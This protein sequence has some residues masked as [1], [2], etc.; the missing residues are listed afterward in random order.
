M[1]NSVGVAKYERRRLNRI[2][3]H[4][5]WRPRKGGGTFQG[6][7]GTCQEEH[8]GTLG[9]Q[10]TVVDHR[11]RQKTSFHGGKIPRGPHIP[12]P[13]GRLQILGASTMGRAS[14]SVFFSQTDNIIPIVQGPLV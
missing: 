12:D 11:N 10:Q 2:P 7:P 9:M 8:V 13:K 6:A 4:R 5:Y 14:Y 1:E 3:G